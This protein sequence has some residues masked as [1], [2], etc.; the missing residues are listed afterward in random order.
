MDMD[1]LC[2]VNSVTNC[3]DVGTNCEIRKTV[4]VV[5]RRLRILI[6][7]LQKLAMDQQFPRTDCPGKSCKLHTRESDPEV[8]QRPSGVITYSTMVGHVLD[9]S[10]RNCERLLKTL[11]YIE[12]SL[13]DSIQLC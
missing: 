5:P 6:S 4:N 7:Q 1:F 9:G 2:R 10:E 11:R 8:V 12:F 3:D 13:H